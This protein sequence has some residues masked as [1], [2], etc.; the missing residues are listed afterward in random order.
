MKHN[1]FISLLLLI[2]LL[3]FSK[4]TPPPSATI[5]G[6]ATV[7]QNSPNP[8]ITFTGSG[9]ATPYTFT[10]HIGLG[11]TQTV[12]TTGSNS[13]I[14]VSAGTG[15]AGSFVYH[16]DSV[17]D[18]SA[19]SV[20]VPI[21]NQNATIIIVSLPIVDFIFTNDN[22]CSGT[23][24]QFLSTVSNAPSAVYSWDFGDGSPLSSSANPNHQF[25]S[26]GCGTITYNVVLTVT[27]GSCTVTKTHTITVKQKPDIAFTDLLNTFSEF[28]NCSGAATNPLFTV[29]VGNVSAS[30]CISSFNIVWGDGNSASNVTFPIT[31][32][33]QTIGVYTMIVTATGTNG[34]T[35]SKSYTIKNIS[36]PLGGINSPGSTQNLCAPT[37]NLQF[38]I[39]SWGSNS[40][41]TTYSVDYGDGSPPL[42]LTQAELN[43]SPYYNALS[44]DQSANYPIPHIYTT[45]SCPAA[46]FQVQLNV[47][48]ACGTTPFTLGNIS[49]L[50]KP[51]ADFT[52]P[53]IACVNNSV[54]FNNTTIAGY[55]Q[56][57]NQNAI[58]TWNFGDGTPIISTT[59]SPPTDISH[60]FNTAGTYTVTLTAQG[61]CGTTT[62]TR[63]ICI[64]PPLVPQFNLST[65]SGCVPLAV[66]ATNTTNL[67]NQCSTPTYNWTVTYTAANCGSTSGYSYTNA[68]TASS[69]SPSFNFTEAGTY[70]VMVTMTNSCGSAASP[71]Q[72]IT[73]KK[74]PTVSLN[75][76]SDFCQNVN[77]TP[78]ANINTCTSVPASVTYLWSFPGGTPATAGTAVPPSVTYAT[79]GN[80]T[81]SLTVTNECG[82][83]TATSNSF[84]VQASPFV[85]NAAL[86]VCSGAAFTF[87]PSN[88]T[89]GNSIPAGTTYSWNVPSVTGG[90]TG[91]SAGLNQ[92]SIS[93][94]ITNNTTALQ[95]ATYTITPKVGGC[96]GTPFILVVSVNPAASITT[97]PVSSSVCLNG[98]PAI[99]S[100]S[101]SNVVVT[102]T[103]QWYQN[104]SNSI[105]GATPV[106]GATA[107][108]YTPPAGSVGT[109]YYYCIVSLS[110][111]GCSSITS[112]IASVTVAPIATITTQPIPT[113]TIC[114]GGSSNA[115][116]VS[117][118]GG[119]GTPTYQWFSNSTN[120]TT[121]GT[122]VGINS[123]SYTPPVFAAPGSYYYYVQV[124]LN[125]N[126][127]GSVSSNT[128]E[129]VV[130]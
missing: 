16:L 109:L 67:T 1:Y 45:S 33:Y 122:P 39:S 124:S 118:S 82:S 59:L 51:T 44:P 73:V 34:C 75:T 48:N 94:T 71:A 91:G 111:G 80:H 126:G 54:L 19:P 95:T 24:I 8:V 28:N 81:V 98:T 5:S 99:L 96:S 55:G 106:A 64:E 120:S 128:A 12:T 30:A 102:P 53:S 63:Q 130:V 11:P 21:N 66:T 17:H 68:T 7:C 92:S 9:G 85:Q 103:Y 60:V 4:E 31:H 79:A 88:S 77:L 117:Y 105:I 15:T 18:A 35:S 89:S 110:S 113:Q 115:L 32:T 116:T 112:T 93:G 43:A 114:V 23:T 121:G 57:C 129:V 46:S 49:V 40:L 14:T 47:T 3:A 72:I 87:T 41:D 25:T 74:P 61:Y 42:Q 76:I 86:T 101:L 127:C 100:I 125:G 83:A 123:A 108:S 78:V 65:N 2:H 13:S 27:N 104:T 84:S 62:K 97:Q 20:E 58:Y 52:N 70:S 36:N 38:T 107:S 50:T 37:P 6:S 90:M 29:N 119:V 69:A 10:Y 56:S 22:T 26:L